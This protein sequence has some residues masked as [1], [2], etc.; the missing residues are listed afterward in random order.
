MAKKSIVSVS[1]GSVLHSKELNPES[2]DSLDLSSQLI[3]VGGLK[4]FL[5]VYTF[6][7]GNEVSYKLSDTVLQ[8][9]EESPHVCL[10]LLFLINC[11]S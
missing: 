11:S 6:V 7:D 1:E 10:F 8:T 3:N 9:M 2:H 4:G 5:L